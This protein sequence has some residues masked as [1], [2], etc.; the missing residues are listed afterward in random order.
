MRRISLAAA[1]TRSSWFPLTALA[2]SSMARSSTPLVSGPLATTSPTS[3]RWSPRLWSKPILPSSASSAARCPC[4]S[5]TNT[6]L[7]PVLLPLLSLLSSRPS[8]SSP[9]GEYR[10]TCSGGR[11]PTRRDCSS[12]KAGRLPLLPGAMSGP[13][14]SSALS[15][16]RSSSPTLSSSSPPLRGTWASAWAVPCSWPLGV[17]D[18]GRGT[19]GG[20]TADDVIMG[21]V[22]RMLVILWRPACRAVRAVRAQTARKTS[23][24]ERKK[25]W[26]QRILPRGRWRWRWRWRI[27]W[28]GA[29]PRRAGRGEENCRTVQ[30]HVPDSAFATKVDYDLMSKPPK[31]SSDAPRWLGTRGQRVGPHTHTQRQ[32]EREHG[33]ASCNGLL[34]APVRVPLAGASGCIA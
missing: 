11:S 21:P 10:G 26:R 16:C 24:P 2:P 14:G 28:G 20:W 8:P 13:A 25:R 29:I 23:A 19:D 4:T 22:D 9:G 18:P 27:S 15:L 30:G 17:R 1:S 31:V 34:R 33:A 5:P 12:Q 3:T 32:R 6:S 7:F